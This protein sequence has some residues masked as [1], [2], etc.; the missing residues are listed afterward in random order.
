[1]KHTSTDGCQRNETAL[2]S[3]ELMQL[4]AIKIFQHKYYVFEDTRKEVPVTRLL[5]RTN[6]RMS[7]LL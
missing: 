3:K 1:M 7:H 6:E 2:I 4:S 5:T